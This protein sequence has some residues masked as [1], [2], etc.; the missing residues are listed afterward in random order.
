MEKDSFIFYL[1][2][3]DSEN[4]MVD[5]KRIIASPLGFSCFCGFRSTFFCVKRERRVVSKRFG[6]TPD[7]GSAC[8]DTRIYPRVPM[9]QVAIGV[10]ARPH[11]AEF[12]EASRVGKR[13]GEVLAF[14]IGKSGA[15]IMKNPG[16]EHLWP[17]EFIQFR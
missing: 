13:S 11:A 4:E 6:G 16:I 9:P 14:V 8:L 10:S 1:G 15:L 7:T 5:R 3:P 17:A 12:E 2:H